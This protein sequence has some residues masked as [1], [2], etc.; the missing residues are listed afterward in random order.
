MNAQH[1][2][3]PWSIALSTDHTPAV[4]VPVHPSEGSGFV[5]AHINRLPRM[6]SVLGDADANAHLIAAAPDMM[7][8]L[9]A[10]D[11]EA[12]DIDADGNIILPSH[13]WDAA[14]AAIAKAEGRS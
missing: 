8:A 5:V 3:G 10:I 7:A 4:T 1:T 12:R 11:I 13:V 9:K 2:P 6:G 14:R